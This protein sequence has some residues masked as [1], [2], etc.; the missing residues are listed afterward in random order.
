M[1]MGNDG[2]RLR[3]SMALE[4]L[5]LRHSPRQLLVGEDAATDSA[6]ASCHSNTIHKTYSASDE[7]GGTDSHSSTS[8]RLCL[9]AEGES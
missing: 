5:V 9:R 6:G 7:V 8:R 3:T 4:A 1:A 2:K